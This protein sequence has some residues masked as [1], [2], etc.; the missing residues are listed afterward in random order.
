MDK[1]LES[2]PVKS[3][4]RAAKLLRI[5][6]EMGTNGGALSDIAQRSGFGKATVHRILA[7]LNDEGF[8]YQDL[9]TRRYHLG[10]GL[11]LLARRAAVGEITSLAKPVLM[12]LAEQTE[13][14]VYIQVR[15]GYRCVCLGREQGSF[16][17]KTL[18][19]SV[20]QSRPL[21]VGSGGLAILANLPSAEIETLIDAN[22]RWLS[23]YPSFD[24]EHL[25]RLIRQ[26][27][28]QGY[29]FVDGLMIPGINAVAVPIRGADGRPIASL[30]VTAIAERIHGDRALWIAGLLGEEARRLSAILLNPNSQNT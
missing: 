10:A 20:G 3:I 15:E 28:A 16:P 17:I 13:D 7:A 30:G 1:D 9:T 29:A 18:S 24:A 21:G 2:A 14:T 25:P 4:S 5:L 19:L 26:T 11:S 8:A 23:E 6:S 22:R 27:Q 12:R